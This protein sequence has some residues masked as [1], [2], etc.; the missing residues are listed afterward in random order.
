MFIV[1]CVDSVRPLQKQTDIDIVM[2]IIQ[3]RT[4]CALRHWTTDITD[5]PSVCKITPGSDAASIWTVF[6]IPT[7]IVIA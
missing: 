2:N 1:C 5:A 6:W 4:I 3:Q 7:K